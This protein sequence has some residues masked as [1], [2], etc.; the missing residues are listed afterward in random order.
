MLRVEGS[1]AA[2]L[3][4]TEAPVLFWVA[5]EAVAQAVE[6]VASE[7]S[8]AVLLVEEEQ[9]VVGKFP[10]CIPPVSPAG[11]QRSMHRFYQHC[12]R[13]FPLAAKSLMKIIERMQDLLAKNRV[14]NL[15]NLGLF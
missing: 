11:K 15:K 2:G 5:S 10:E 6:E 13:L 8:A 7:V 9:A 4:S 14:D 12:A 3:T 1:A